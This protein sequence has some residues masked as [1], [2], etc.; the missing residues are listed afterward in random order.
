MPG[1]P[2]VTVPPEPPE[3]FV[4]PEPNCPAAV[5]PLPATPPF[6]IIGVVDPNVVLPP[7]FPL[8]PPLPVS[9]PPAPTV[10]V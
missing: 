5:V 9:A 1:S 2:K 4:P 6:A 8:A 7:L 3:L 10:T